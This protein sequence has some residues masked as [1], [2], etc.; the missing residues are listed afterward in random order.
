M[1]NDDIKKREEEKIIAA[2]EM[3][4]SPPAGESILSAAAAAAAEDS[5]QLKQNDHGD[6]ASS[7][8]TNITNAANTTSNNVNKAKSC[9]GCLYYSSRFKADSRNPLCV[10]LTRSLPNVPRYI[11]GESEM[12]A[13]KEGRS[14]TD[15]RY[16]CVGYS[17]YTD[18][19]KKTSDGQQTQTELPVCVGLEVLVDRRVNAADSASASAPSQIHIKEDGNGLPQ[20]RS[21]KP[22]N[23]NGEEFL[24]RFTRNAN[25]VANGVAKNIRKVGNQIKQS[26]GDI[27]YPYRRP[28]K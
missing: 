19:K 1:E 5:N 2:A 3:A 16:A 17:L 24:S 14:F 22:T 25:L 6:S 8:T 7:S 27:L 11:V 10:G 13:S 21:P 28:P 4:A 18:Q 20:H 12:E 15:F 23:S 9:K 26:L